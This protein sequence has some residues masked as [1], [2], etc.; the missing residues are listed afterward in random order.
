MDGTHNALINPATAAAADIDTMMTQCKTIADL[1]TTVSALTQQPHQAN[2]ANN[3]GSGTPVERQGQAN[4]KWVNGKHIRDVG[5]YF[6]THGYC[7]DINHDSMACQIKKE[8]HRDN[9]TRANNM[10][11]NQYG[12]PRAWVWERFGKLISNNQ[13]KIFHNLRFKN[14]YP[15]AGSGATLNCLCM[16]NPSDYEKRIEPIRALLLDENKI[17]VQIQCQMKMDGIPEQAKKAYK[18]DNI[19]EPIMSI[20]VLCDNGCTVTFTKQSVHV[21]KYEKNLNRL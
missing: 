17:Q 16:N 12:K 2:V 19:R 18:S 5:G 9:A 15:I 4:P 13:I 6:W 11:G 7:V 20:P 3:R 1:T 21:K 10:G 14:L 8:G